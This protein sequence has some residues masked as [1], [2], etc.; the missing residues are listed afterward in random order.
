M[1]RR[2]WIAIAVVLTVVA[3][4][5]GVVAWRVA[6]DDDTRLSAAL[7]L[8]P[9]SS[10]RFVWT[11]WAAV[12]AELGADLDAASSGAEVEDFLLDAFDRDLLSGTA[13][14]ESAPT[15]QEEMGFSP[16]TVD[17]EMFSQGSKGAV[18]ALGLPEDFDTAALRDR[19]RSIG[20]TD[21]RERDGVWV[22]GVDV[23]ETLG[24]PVT[25]ELAAL[26]IDDEAGVLYG[27]DDPSF[28]E[29]RADAARGDREDGV[30]RAVAAVGPSLSAVAYTGDHACGQ[31][32]MAEADPTER[33][34]AAELVEQAGGLHP[35]TGFAM[36]A[37]AG[38]DVRVALTLD[39]EDQARADADS[40]SRLAAGP[41]PG[42]GGTFP[43]RFALGDVVADGQVVTMDLTP[44]EG[45]SV[46]SDL[47]QGPVLFASC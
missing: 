10:E 31:L 7:E 8:A 24:G 44:V 40:R 46:L 13:L 12:R 23:L 18:V 41:A 6:R 1:P 36:S 26:Q 28:L 9:E 25:P 37:R 3:V 33:T 42:Q 45:W 5:A 47:S 29:D 14:A 32:S 11:D 19:I 30:A 22:G 27:S 35:L 4:A 34:R 15:I 17:W 39:G 2:R 21:P 16:A 38:G 43:E 20:F